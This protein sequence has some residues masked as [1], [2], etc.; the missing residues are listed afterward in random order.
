MKALPEYLY[1]T[2]SRGTLRHFIGNY[3]AVM[4]ACAR[5]TQSQYYCYGEGYQFESPWYI[6]NS[7][8]DLLKQ[9]QPCEVPAEIQ[10][11]HLLLYRGHHD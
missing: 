3:N 6:L 7:N 4:K 8:Y 1:W 2:D 5:Y 9:L 10:A 11:L